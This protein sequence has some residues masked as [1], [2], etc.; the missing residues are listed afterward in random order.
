MSLI[1]EA[2]R[3]AQQVK[4]RKE[5]TSAHNGI[6]GDILM[7]SQIVVSVPQKRPLSQNRLIILGF[8]SLLL[9]VSILWNTSLFRKTSTLKKEV[10]IQETTPAAIFGEKEEA[11]S[12]KITTLDASY[13]ATGSKPEKII[14]QEP[15][16]SIRHQGKSLALVSREEAA[17]TQPAT[18]KPVSP[19][20]SSFTRKSSK[21]EK[22]FPNEI[23]H[24]LNLGLSYQ[25]TNHTATG[26]KAYG[27]A[28]DSTE[29]D[30]LQTDSPS[31][32]LATRQQQG[33]DPPRI[34][35]GPL[36]VK[37]ESNISEKN[38]NN[39]GVTYYLQGDLKQAVEQFKTAIQLN[40]NSIESYVNL[41]I[42]YKKQ[43]RFEDALK[44]YKKAVS[45]KPTFPE[46]Y[47]NLGI[48]Y[49]DAGDFKRAAGAY[50]RFLQLAPEKYQ[51][52]KQKAQKR[53]NI[54]QSY[55]KY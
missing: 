24:Y 6:S 15:A 48:L 55:I 39:L 23:R 16:S 34:A 42:I 54:I 32:S 41:G 4:I 29:Q 12:E 36:H 52:Q 18:D 37:A 1:S 8:L 50:R 31:A 2:L 49:D 21:K 40:P 26:K 7:G 10:P 19:E 3:R 33:E 5:K 47:Y 14:S 13:K 25:S 30:T 20:A 43:N 35:S 22:A 51:S 46:P 11:L 9:V 45:L 44:A 53:L 27:R 38:Y 17:L 28:I